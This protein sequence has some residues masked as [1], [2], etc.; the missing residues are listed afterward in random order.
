[1]LSK[2]H[3]KT[4]PKESLNSVHGPG[5]GHLKRLVS[6]RTGFHT[7]FHSPICGRKWGVSHKDLQL[8]MTLEIVSN[9]VHLVS[10]PK[11]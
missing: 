9:V 1:M 11:R 7:I 5:I 6:K 2:H 4:L 10:S 3:F 8:I